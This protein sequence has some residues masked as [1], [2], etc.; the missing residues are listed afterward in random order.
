M[1]ELDAV[2]RTE[3]QPGWHVLDADGEQIGSVEDVTDASFTIRVNGPSEALIAIS[4]DDI[5]SADDGR[6][7]LAVSGGELAAM[8]RDVEL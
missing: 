1:D 3:I 2:A 4:F 5:E 7:E 8:A 6:V